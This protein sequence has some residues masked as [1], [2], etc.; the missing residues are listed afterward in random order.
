VN[1]EV[2]AR[3]LVSAAMADNDAPISWITLEQGT[4]VRSSDGEE[5]GSV[6]EVIADR[7]KDIFSGLTIDSGLLS[8][9]RFAPADVIEDIS[10]DGVRLTISASEAEDLAD[11][12]A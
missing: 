8:S 7:Q 6:H 4:V 12:E 5:V 10:T 9:K 11:Y 1:G 2:D 3:A